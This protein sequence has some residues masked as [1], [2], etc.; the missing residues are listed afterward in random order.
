MILK[1]LRIG[2]IPSYRPNAGNY[3]G[4]A[5]FTDEAGNVAL[6]LTPEMCDKI[7]VICAD[8]ILSVAQDAA[9]NL[10]CNIIEHQKA[11]GKTEKDNDHV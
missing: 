2:M 1:E 9:R 11:L 3:E 7:F 10:T 6:K 5:E 4:V 8:G